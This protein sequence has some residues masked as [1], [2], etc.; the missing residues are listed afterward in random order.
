MSERSKVIE[1]EEE[2]EKEGQV[3]VEKGKAKKCEIRRLKVVTEAKIEV[4]K[5]GAG[6]NC[7]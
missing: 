2:N 1:C 4:V 7:K 3:F 5:E 6:K